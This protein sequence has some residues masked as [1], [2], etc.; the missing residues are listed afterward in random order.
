M[1]SQLTIRNIALVD[2]ISLAFDPGMNVLT[3]ETGAGKSIIVDA[4]SFLLGGRA[5]RDIIRAGSSQAYVEGLFEL[6][7]NAEALAF[8]REYQMDAEEGA[9]ILS[10]E[11]NQNGRSLCRING[12]AVSLGLLRQ[13]SS[14]LMDIHGQH[15]HQSLLDERRHLQYLDAFGGEK[16]AALLGR[17]ASAYDKYHALEKEHQQARDLFARRQERQ[18][19]LS[20]QQKELNAARLEAGEEDS[21]KERVERLRNA[22]RIRR[23]LKEAYAALYDQGQDGAAALELLRSARA[24]LEQVSGYDPAYEQ[25]RARVDSLYYEVEDVGLDL[26]SRLGML[27]SDEGSLQEAAQR[28]DQLKRL[29]RKYGMPSDQLIAALQDIEREL[30]ELDTVEERLDSLAA[31]LERALSD[32]QGEA[33]ALTEARKALALHLQRQME[34]QLAALNMA[35]TRFYMHF[36]EPRQTPHREGQDQVRMLLAPNLGEE[37]KPLSKIAS[38]GE[39]SRL[40]L[41]LKAIAAELSG[42]PAMIFDEIDT[43]ISG[44][45]AQV[46]A[47]KLWD[48]ARYR[49]VLC[50]THL[51]QIAAMASSHYL[52]EK[53]EEEGRTVTTLTKLSE[54]G[55]VKEL[56]R[57]ISGFSERSDSSLQHAAHMLSEAAAYRER[58]KAQKGPN[59]RG[60][61]EA[62]KGQIRG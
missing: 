58:G 61:G 3:G 39:T 11:L 9:V 49:Q 6:D 17:V 41:A 8:L 34:E 7:G 54:A 57:I 37:A 19:L 20:A 21:L 53:H 32:Y 45:T 1:L 33:A 27:D 2:Q 59:R 15:E 18:M 28:L 26:R 52:V 16:Q 24:S 42:I 29:G 35:G 60:A 5:D 51:Q 43:G 31:E 55:R 47:E 62:V 14:L 10:R 46:V 13:L 50:V 40:M 44:R 56:S 23:S 48:I 4:V 38:G 22:D 12:V 25:A 30:A 36:D